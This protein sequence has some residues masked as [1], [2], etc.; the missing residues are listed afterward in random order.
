MRY[1]VVTEYQVITRYNQVPGDD[2]V[3]R[4]YMVPGAHWYQMKPGTLL[5]ILFQVTTW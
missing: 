3:L 1:L 2:L 4:A 5:S